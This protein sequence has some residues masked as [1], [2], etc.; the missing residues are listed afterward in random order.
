MEWNKMEWNKNSLYEL[1]N[2]LLLY[3]LIDSLHT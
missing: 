1:L 3:T 2:A